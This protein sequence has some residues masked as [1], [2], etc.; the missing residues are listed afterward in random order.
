[1][2]LDVLFLAPRFG[3]QDATLHGV[4]CSGQALGTVLL[5]GMGGCGG[6]AVCGAG[7]W[8]RS[9]GGSTHLWRQPMKWRHNC[10]WRGQAHVVWRISCPVCLCAPQASCSS[11]GLSCRVLDAL[12]H[13]TAEEREHTLGVNF[14]PRLHHHHK[15]NLLTL[16]YTTTNTRAT[17][18][19][20][21]VE[22]P[23]PRHN[24]H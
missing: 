24:P 16:H 9:S 23:T 15:H 13:L 1:M 18:L 19:R 2:A 8:W 22:R 12:L 5:R 11:T 3:N 21:C 6:A 20:A 10:D 7:D 17:T 4:S 14:L